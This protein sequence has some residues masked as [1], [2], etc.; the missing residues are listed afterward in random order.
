MRKRILQ[1]IAFLLAVMMLSAC[2]LLPEEETLPAMP[3]IR[4]YSVAQYKQTPVMRG[5]MISDVTVYCTYTCNRKESI[6]FPLGGLYIE[7]VAVSEGDSVK[8]G[9]FLAAVERKAIQEQLEEQR[10]ELNVLYKEKKHLKETLDLELGKYGEMIAQLDA[11]MQQLQQ[12]LQNQQIGTDPADLQLQ[13][14]SLTQQK[15]SLE[16]KRAAAQDKYDLQL[17]N[18]E[19]SIYIEY[20]RMQEL[21]QTLSEHQIFAGIDGTVTYVRQVEEGQRSSKGETFVSIADMEAAAFV[22]DKRYVEYFPFG[23]EVTISSAGTKY[24]T[25]VV[26]ATQVGLAAEPENERKAVYFKM[27]EQDLTLTNNARGNTV[28]TLEQHLDVLYVHE[29]GIHTSNG[30][31]F[32]YILDADGLRTMKAVT[33]GVQINEFVEIVSGLNEGDYVITN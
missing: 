25:V 1:T 30:E 21:E 20:L 7:E 4:E 15:Q 12:D 22:A 2:Q 5:D 29:D 13:L 31:N 33:I 3:V 8:A 17:Q 27:K 26:D 18:V 9:D 10:Y 19:D 11:Q 23:M 6:S 24:E 28:V 14:E 16:L 32:V